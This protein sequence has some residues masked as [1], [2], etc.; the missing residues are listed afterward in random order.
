M[1]IPLDLNRAMEVDVD[2][3]DVIKTEP[4]R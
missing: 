4:R 1:Y 2:P 3:A